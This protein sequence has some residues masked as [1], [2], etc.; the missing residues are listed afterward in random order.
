MTIVER[1]QATYFIAVI[2]QLATAHDGQA[3]S[4]N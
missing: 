1:Y 3:H 4:F 2:L